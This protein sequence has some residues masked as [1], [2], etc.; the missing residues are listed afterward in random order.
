[1]DAIRSQHEEFWFTDITGG[2]TRHFLWAD[3]PDE[4]KMEKKRSGSLTGRQFG[5]LST[6]QRARAASTTDK[7][8]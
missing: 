3:G 8:R 7:K 1:M 4:A 5:P 2:G 6:M